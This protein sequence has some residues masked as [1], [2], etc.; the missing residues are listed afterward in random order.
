MCNIGRPA[1]IVENFSPDRI[2]VKVETG[3]IALS[4]ACRTSRSYHVG[5]IFLAL[6]SALKTKPIASFCSKILDAI[7]AIEPHLVAQF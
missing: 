4:I 5:I 6:Q 2:S 1:E 7:F 3:E